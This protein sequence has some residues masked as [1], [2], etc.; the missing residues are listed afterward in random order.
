VVSQ[1]LSEELEQR[2]ALEKK[3]LLEK[4]RARL[5][6]EFSEQVA[7]LK[8]R[9]EERDK[10]L[11]AARSNELKL[12]KLQRELENER[13]NRELEVARKIAAERSKIHKEAEGTAAAKQQ[14]KIADRDRTIN[15]LK[16][17]LAT[18]QQR[19]EQQSQ[20]H[21]GEVLELQLEDWLRAA[22]P[23]DEIEPISQGKNGADILHT[24]KT[25]AGKV[26]GKILWETKRTRRW[27]A[28]WLE[29]L[30]NDQ[31]AAGADFG[32]LLSVV[33][34]DGV[35]RFAEHEGLWITSLDCATPLAGA[36]RCALH[37]IARTNSLVVDRRKKADVLYQ[38]IC[39][40]EFRQTVEAMI[41]RFQSMRAQLE[42]E[43]AAIQRTWSKREQHLSSITLHIAE[44]FGGMQGIVGESALPT[45]AQLQ[46]PE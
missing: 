34:P 24:I 22:F 16:T 44:L 12:L 36:L 35:K 29:K 15:D 33:L 11:V 1:Q 9:L 45:P 37:Q 39:S 38:H 7:D 13:R 17:Q 43:K 19:L 28:A 40:L 46:L 30:K 5:K 26:C 23:D 32:V 21:Q 25:S 2:W 18:L 10:R 14:L 3:Q 4:E 42:Q 6:S 8:Q 31:R 20:Q 41:Q 27:N